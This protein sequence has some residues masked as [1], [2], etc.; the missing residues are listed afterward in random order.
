MFFFI[1]YIYRCTNLRVV[2]F[3]GLADA[4]QCHFDG[5]VKQRLDPHHE[6]GA[7]KGGHTVA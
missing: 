4:G 5:L 7:V 1:I 3:D 2:E 6:V